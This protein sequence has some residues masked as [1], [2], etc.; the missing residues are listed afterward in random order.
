MTKKET[1]STNVVKTILFSITFVQI[2]SGRYVYTYEI[3]LPRAQN[4]NYTTSTYKE[5]QSRYHYQVHGASHKIPRNSR[6]IPAETEPAVNRKLFLIA[7]F[8]K[9]LF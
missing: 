8:H 4:L 6:H 3:C 7:G 5:S 2:S 1:V 9:T